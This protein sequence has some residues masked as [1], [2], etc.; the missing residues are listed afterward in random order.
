MSCLLLS[1]RV[2]NTALPVLRKQY[3]TL[4]EAGLTDCKSDTEYAEVEHLIQRQKSVAW[5]DQTEEK[6]QNQNHEIEMSAIFSFPQLVS[7][8]NTP[9]RKYI[10][11][12]FSVGNTL[13]Q[14][15][16]IIHKHSCALLQILRPDVKLSLRPTFYKFYTVLNWI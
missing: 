7:R 12:F 10:I 8:P 6:N 15:S 16:D 5:A 1:Y 9:C 13:L 11:K 4:R 2:L 3:L 14:Q